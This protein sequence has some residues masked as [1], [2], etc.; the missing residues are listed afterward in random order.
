MDTLTDSEEMARRVVSL[1][2]DFDQIRQAYGDGC[3]SFVRDRLLAR[4]S[5][6]IEDVVYDA[7]REWA[8]AN[9]RFGLDL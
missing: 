4:P 6:P 2:D 1:L 7:V 5:G 9:P 3:V 8:Q